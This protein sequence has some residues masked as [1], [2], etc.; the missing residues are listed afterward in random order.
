MKSHGPLTSLADALALVRAHAAPLPIETVPLSEA[1]GR[2]LAEGVRSSRD[3]PAFD[4]SMMDGFAV[5]A[6]DRISRVMFA[7]KAGDGPSPRPLGPGESARIFTGA[8]VPEGA[9]AVVMQEHVQREGDALTIPET[10][11]PGQHIRRRG[12]EVKAGAE[13]LPAGARLGPAELALV[14]SLKASVQ[15]RRRPRVALLS[16][17]DELVPTGTEPKPGQIVE[18]NSLAL[19]QL[20]RECGA[21]PILLGTE[22]DEPQG[23]AASLASVEADLLIT[24]GGASVGDHDHAQ[25]ALEHLGGKLLFHS[26]AIRPGKP[27][28]FGTAGH[29]ARGLPRVYLGL[30]GN[31]AASM[32]GFE[33]L[34]RVFL[35]LLQGDPKPERTLAK[36]V[37]ASSPLSRVPGLV[38]FPRGRVSV[39]DGKLVFTPLV[40]QGSMQI[41]SWAAVNAVAR[42]EPGTGKIE[43]GETIEALLVGP[44]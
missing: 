12:E 43:P 37:L 17:G 35:R 15:V 10:T 40:Q 6:A 19:A 3:L 18:T 39:E 16:T 31:P 9:D 20:V 4:V 32:L 41:A 25:A 14:G 22:G 1:A 21:E 7:V 30:P 2:I 24:T 11:K 23:I 29:T 38:F 33:L 13:V 44:I 28:L 42:I 5:R 26:V 8:P 34:A 36:C 27:I